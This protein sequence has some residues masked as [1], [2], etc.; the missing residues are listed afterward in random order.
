MLKRTITLL[1]LTITVGAL[2]LTIGCG[3][4]NSNPVTDSFVQEGNLPSRIQGTAQVT[5]V[6]ASSPA[7]V[8]VEETANGEGIASITV[9]DS[10]GGR[11]YYFPKGAKSFEF[12]LPN[13][14]SVAW[15]WILVA[16]T[17]NALD[18]IWILYSDGRLIRVR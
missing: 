15:H 9:R 4:S 3:G 13:F 1:G 10:A 17:N 16:D 18:S 7:V 5:L 14:G 12:T 6:S 8:R 11:A 2:L